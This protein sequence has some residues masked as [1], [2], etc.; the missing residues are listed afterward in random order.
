ML[1]VSHISHIKI[2][3]TFTND[4]ENFLPNDISS[5][6]IDLSHAGQDSVRC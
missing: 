1:P 3:G 2:G 5:I 4:V 6:T